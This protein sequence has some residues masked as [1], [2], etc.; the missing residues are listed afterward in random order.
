MFNTKIDL[1]FKRP[2]NRKAV[3]TVAAF[4]N[5]VTVKITPFN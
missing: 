2:A 3:C 4:N 5:T 1:L